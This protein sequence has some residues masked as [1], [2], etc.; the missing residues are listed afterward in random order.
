MV[1]DALS[2]LSMDSVAHVE[3]E[4][5]ELAKEV[6]RLSQLGVRLCNTDD[7]GL[8]VLKGRSHLL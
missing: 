1:D 7:G 3:K 4:K 8:M 2:R 6:Y 5:K